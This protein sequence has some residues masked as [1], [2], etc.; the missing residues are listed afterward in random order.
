MNNKLRLPSKI[1]AEY[2]LRTNRRPTKKHPITLI[3]VDG[4]HNF[5]EFNPYTGEVFGKINL[6]GRG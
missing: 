1:A 5:Y 2:S 3:R 4:I 6:W